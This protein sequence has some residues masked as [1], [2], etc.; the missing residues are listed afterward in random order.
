[1][2]ICSSLLLTSAVSYY[3]MSIDLLASLSGLAQESK[4]F[5]LLASILC[6]FGGKNVNKWRPTK[7]G[8]VA[9]LWQAS[10]LAS[11]C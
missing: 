8:Q 1:M 3:L 6:P 9:A 2:K 5:I 7:D 4:N 11:F 10:W